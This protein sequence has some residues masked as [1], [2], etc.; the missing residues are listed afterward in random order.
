MQCVNSPLTMR[1]VVTVVIINEEND[2]PRSPKRT[3]MWRGYKSRTTEHYPKFYWHLDEVYI[4][5][6]PPLDEAC[7]SQREATRYNVAF[8]SI[9]DVL[10]LA[11]GG[12]S[13]YNGVH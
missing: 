8:G 1:R 4:Y 3:G 2:A 6:E 12:V 10:T 9:C 11:I 7:D 13:S 5:H